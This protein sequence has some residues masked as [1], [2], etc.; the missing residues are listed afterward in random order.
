MALKLAFI[1]A[2]EWFLST[3][4]RPYGLRPFKLIAD[5]R[6]IKMNIKMYAYTV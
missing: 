4:N 6:V 1:T 5:R 3:I 2:W